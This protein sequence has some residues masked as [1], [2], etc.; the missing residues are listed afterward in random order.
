MRSD[1]WG[2]VVTEYENYRGEAISVPYR[3]E[4]AV[5]GLPSERKDF[6]ILVPAIKVGDTEE[7]TQFAIME[8]SEYRERR[9]DYPI[10]KLAFE[11]SP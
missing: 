5:S 1:R 3:A 10:K 2:R 8:P 6:L 9:K 7:V 4:L 11:P